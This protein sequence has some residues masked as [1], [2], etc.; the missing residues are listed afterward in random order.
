MIQIKIYNK[1]YT[2]L[3]AFNTGEFGALHYRKTL[4][5]IGDASFTLDISSAKVTD[6][7]M[8]NY[9]R[10]EILD[11]GVVQWTGYIVSKQVTLNMVTIQCKELIGILA[12]RI[13]TDAYVMSGNAGTLVASLLST[14]N[15]I[16][17]TG[18]T[19]GDTDISTSI[20]LT[21]NQ[22]DV[23]SALRDVA[24]AVGGQFVVNE[25]RTLDFKL[26]IGQD[27]S[28]SVRLEY[29]ILQPQQANLIKFNVEDNGEN[30]VTKSYGT[31]NTLVSNQSD[32]AL[33]TLYGILEKFS[34]YPQANNQTNLDALTA[35]VLADTL[36]SPSLDLSPGELDN[37]NIGDLVAVF[38]KNKLVYID[39]TFQVL[40][41]S[42]KIVNSQKSISV[43]INQL[44]QTIVNNIKDLQRQVNLLQTN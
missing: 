21:F 19:M 15:G 33:Q 44:P 31:N 14:I 16:E 34:S 4:G 13:T 12:K 9:N 17:N 39:D 42:V 11:G 40:E 25:D 29:N 37:F 27:L 43:K 22:Q 32:G 6:T 10:L 36:Y 35:S 1:T 41:K 5:Q 3:T 8:R 7:N 18:I 23:L 2:P 24:D 28:S 20:N 38:V 26:N 30:V